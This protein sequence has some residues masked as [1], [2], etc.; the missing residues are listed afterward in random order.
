VKAAPRALPYSLA[1]SRLARRVA[2]TGGAGAAVGRV[3]LWVL[4]ELSPGGAAG[5]GAGAAVRRPVLRKGSDAARRSR[6]WA[7]RRRTLHALLSCPRTLPGDLLRG[8]MLPWRGRHATPAG[9][10]VIASIKHHRQQEQGLPRPGTDFWANKVQME[11]CLCSQAGGNAVAVGSAGARASIARMSIM[12]STTCPLSL[13]CCHSRGAAGQ[14]APGQP[15][16]A[17]GRGRRSRALRQRRPHH[18][19]ARRRAT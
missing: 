12:T 14:A 4:G 19:G 9:C 5:Q 2:A 10:D 16:P 7:V 18:R 6:R 15:V 3:P 11:G 8:S 17:A 1:R 13:H